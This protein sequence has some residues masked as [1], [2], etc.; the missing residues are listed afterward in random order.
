[1][2]SVFNLKALGLNSMPNQLDVPD[3]SLTIAKNINI[4]RDNVVEPRRG[5]NLYGNSFGSTTDRA[6]QLINYKLRILRHYAST[7]QFD[8]GEGNFF[9]FSDTI[10]ETET[11]LRIKSVESNGNLY[12]TTSAGIKKISAKTA[13]DFST[14]AD[15]VTSAGAVKA[16]DIAGAASYE[17]GNQTGFLTQ[18]SAVAYRVVWGYRDANKNLLI[19]SPSQRI[20][21]YNPLLNL[22]IPDYMHLLGALDDIGRSGSIISDQN[23]VNTLKLD[24][25]ASAAELR[26]NLISLVSKIDND[27]L[28]ADNDGAPTGA[29]LEIDTATISSGVCT[30]TFA[31]GDP[32]LYVSAGSSIYLSGFSP[33]TGTLN[34]AQT[35][36]SVNSTQIT[37]NTAATGAVTVSGSAT[38]V[39]NTYRAIA[40]PTAPGTPPTNA[41]L[42]ELQDYVTLIIEALIAEPNAVI[43]NTLSTTYIDVLDVTTASNVDL[44]ITIP[45][46]ITSDY[47]FQIYRS[48]VFS[49]TGVQVLSTDVFPNDELQL[50]YEAFPTSAELAA[51]QVE[52]EDIVPDAF[53]GANLYTNASTGEGI[54]QANDVP[55]FAKD[56]N[57]FKNSVFYANTYTRHRKDVSLLGVQ[58]MI[59]DYN[60]SITPTITISTESSY[61][62]YTFVIG[63]AEVFTIDCDAGSTLAASGT[64]DYFDANS[65]ENGQ[66]FR[67]WYKIGTAVAPA[68]GG[69]QLVQILADAGDTATQIAEKTR[70]AFNRLSNYFEA[71]NL[72]D[73]VTVTLSGVGETTDPVDGTT[74]FSFTVTNQGVGENAT[75]KQILLSDNISPAIAVQE[76]AQSLTRVVNKNASENVYVYYT[77]GAQEVPGKMVFEGRGLDI[78]E[79]SIVTNNS[80]TG[81]S[82]NPSFAPTLQISSITTGSPSTMT[83]VTSAAHGLTNLDY[84]YISG[85]N[86]TP[87]IDGY[88]QITYVNSTTFRVN[89]TVTV[90]G[91]VGGVIPATSIESSSNEES[92]NR[93][94]Y[95]KFQQPEAVP[96]LNYF[97]VGA[98][99]RAI[100]RIFPL[101]DSLFVFKEDGIYRISGE[102]IPFNLAL[103]DGSTKL[104]AADSI[105]AVGNVIYGWTDEGVVSITESGT[106]NVSRP[107]DIDLLPLAS[108]S[109]TSFPTA[110]WGIGYDS[111]K[112]YTVFTIKKTT[113]TYAKQG[114]KY[115]TLTNAWS[116]IDKD[117]VCGVIN[118][119]DDKMYVGAGDTNFIEQ[120][121]KNFTRED[122]ADRDYDLELES[123]FTNTV[124]NINDVTNVSDNDVLVQEQTVSLYD[125]NMLL[126]KLDLDPGTSDDYFDD[127]EAVTGD[128]I[129]SKLIALA[130]KLD[131]D[132]LQFTNYEASIDDLSGSITTISTGSTVSITSTGHGLVTG[133]IVSISGT[134]SVPNI[135]GEYAVT[136][137]GVNTFTVQPGFTVTTAGTAG[138]FATVV[139]DFVDHQVCYNQLISKLNL[140]TTV[141]FSN[142]MSLSGTKLQ[143]VL[144]TDVNIVAERI[145]ISSEIPLVLGDIKVYKSIDCDVLYSPNTFGGD[146]V[147]LKHM[148][149]A[150][151]MFD[152]LAFT[153]ATI[154][155]ATDL[156]PQFEEV[157]LIADG[158]GIFGFNEFGNGFFG[159]A[160]HGA[161][162]RT[163]IPRNCQ[164][165]RYM[166]VR[167]NHRVAREKWALYGISLIGETQLSER[168]YR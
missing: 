50:V 114:Y 161:P 123:L 57:V 87:N 70:D 24:L 85:S 59:E 152:N 140:D 79:F 32:S 100:L 10:S 132:S 21:V 94:Y 78:G 54:L 124:L 158:N 61:N 126:K 111:D 56:I 81:A 65:A 60:N 153:Q 101:R 90:A 149:D 46:D 144:I 162:I 12:L 27:I 154:S 9:S 139:T 35:V 3:G 164:R 108:S 116:T 77:S 39:S 71:S 157:E 73:V 49:A 131:T 88:R 58:S 159:G 25:T 17:Y 134:N 45:E 115:N 74:G 89:V 110:T 67:F 117:F 145:T 84:V 122:H 91:T 38:I 47:F 125:Y 106:S 82:F 93:V 118:F 28:Y 42:V 6:K 53:R 34:G 15:Y 11:G 155:F 98:R 168:S 165:C 146:P 19:G 102:S 4:L 133:R 55:P 120:E 137:T 69:R 103:F 66:L 151:V 112:S 167:F 31:S 135:N 147:S 104:L 129:R 80:N 109:Y 29:P 127:L 97:D 95:S 14:T 136:V 163:Y 20:E 13:G 142:Y 7:L 5:F 18:D 141:A 68:A 121:R 119:A 43:D 26:T 8:D 148:R 48:A 2:P 22:L 107:I 1:M 52:V 143:E 16:V 156:L 113:D 130:Q 51:S 63:E 105:D 86:S 30:V 36:A 96:I 33:A 72:V 128:S 160:S 62:T 37:F 75:N 40:Q 92:P 41:E 138:S 150:Q 23:Y 166:L 83:V 44:K 99:D 76:T 64:A